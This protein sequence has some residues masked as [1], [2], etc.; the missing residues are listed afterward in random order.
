MG[1]A[2]KAAPAPAPPEPAAPPSF[3]ATFDEFAARWMVNSFDAPEEFLLNYEDSLLDKKLHQIF[4]WPKSGKN[5]TLDPQVAQLFTRSLKLLV[6]VAQHQSDPKARDVL[7]RWSPLSCAAALGWPRVVDLL[8]RAGAPVDQIIDGHNPL[9]T[10]MMCSRSCPKI[11]DADYLGVARR[12]LEG[13]ADPLYLGV[14]TPLEVARSRGD[15]HEFAELLEAHPRVIRAERS[16]TCAYCHGVGALVEPAFQACAG[17][18]VCRYCSRDCQRAH[19]PS[20][21]AT[22]LASPR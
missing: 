21:R 2:G 12:L 19:W 5:K 18:M 10:S 16:R 14:W 15:Y 4:G 6:T 3:P 13:G 8:L 7:K 9:V 1:A 22:C 17:C 20:H 11:P